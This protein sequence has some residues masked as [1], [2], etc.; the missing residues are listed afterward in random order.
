MALARP[1]DGSKLPR[2]NFRFILPLGGWCCYGHAVTFEND[3]L[4]RPAAAHLH[5]HSS[6]RGHRLRKTVRSPRAH[7]LARSLRQARLRRQLRFF[8]RL[9]HR[10]VSGSI[11]APTPATAGGPPMQSPAC[12]RDRSCGRTQVP[13]ASRRRGRCRK[14]ACSFLAATRSIRPRQRR[15]TRPSCKLRS[16]TRTC[17]RPGTAD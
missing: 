5:W 11:S 16:R 13:K 8:L 4:V 15:T 9:A 6:H 2:F 1:Y 14:D 17:A 12:S 7:R 10:R 3:G